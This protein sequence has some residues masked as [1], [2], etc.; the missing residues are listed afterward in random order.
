M[1]KILIINGSLGGATGNTNVLIN[2]CC[3]LISEKNFSTD[4]IHLHDFFSTHADNS[5]LLLKKELQSAD[6]FL[7]TSGTYW[8]S[9][10]SPMQRFLET[11]TDLEATDV[12]MGKACA[13]VITMHSVGGKEVL[14]R[15]QGVLNTMG[16]LIPPMSGLVYA[17]STHL[18]LQSQN[19]FAKDFWSKDDL[20]IVLHNLSAGI[21]GEKTFMAWPVDK[22][23]PTRLWNR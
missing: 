11:I 18:A 13:V 4:V 19:D 22:K 2:E 3:K 1:K 16:L 21:H 10:G 6:G 20:E 9:W 8:D 12:L 23:D 15:L 14:S 5:F 7:F 17:L